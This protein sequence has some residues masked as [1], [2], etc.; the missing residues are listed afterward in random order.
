MAIVDV[1]SELSMYMFHLFLLDDFSY[2]DETGQEVSVDGVQQRIDM[3][4]IYSKPVDAASGVRINKGTGAS[5]T[6]TELHN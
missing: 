4:F 6:L 5:E 3:V 2:I 1:P